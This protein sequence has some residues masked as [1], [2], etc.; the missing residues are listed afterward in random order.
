[1]IRKF[2]VFFAG[3]SLPLLAAASVYAAAVDLAWDPPVPGDGGE[4]IG[5]IVYGSTTEGD[6]SDPV[7]V[8]IVEE[9]FAT[10]SGLDETRTYYF[11]V[12]AYNCAGIGDPS[13]EIELAANSDSFYDDGTS[14]DTSN[15]SKGGG[16]GGGCFIATAAYGSAYEPQ[17]RILKEFR[18][19]YL[20]QS[21]FGRSLVDLYYRH[22]PA[23]AD[24]IA[25]HETLKALTRWGLAPAVWMAKVSLHTSMMQKIGIILAVV[26]AFAGIWGYVVK[27]FKVH[28]SRLRV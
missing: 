8:E 10:V 21:G 23:L 5:Y 16:G 12:K 20:L 26:I 6:Y 4:V 22:S 3:L 14:D 28:G 9:T 19:S 18:D 17:V 1:M 15:S 25:D 27:R 7:A 2:L 24:A 11:V 13:N